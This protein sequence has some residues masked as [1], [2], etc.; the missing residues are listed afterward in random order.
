MAVAEIA[1]LN[2]ICPYYTMYPLTFPIAALARA[3]R[4]P[5]WV[6]DPFCGRGTTNYAAR[7]L[8]LPTIG[9]DSSPVAAA[10]AAAKMADTTEA[11]V[12]R[13]AREILDEGD[14]GDMPSGRF[15]E[16]AYH[17]QVL[18]DLCRL[19]TAL[20]RDCTSDARIVLRAIILG[21]LHGPTAKGAPFNFSNQAP[22]S[23]APKPNYAVK[24]WRERRLKPPKVDV[25]EVIRRRAE[26]YLAAV[27]PKVNGYIALGDSRRLEIPRGVHPRWVVTSPPYYGTRTYVPDQWLR[28]W[29]LGGPARVEYGQRPQDLSHLSSEVFASGLGAVWRRVAESAHKQATLII[30]FGAIGD[31]EVDPR[32]LL[33][34]SLSG[35]GWRLV[36]IRRAGDASDGKRQ[37]QQ[38]GRVTG[39]PRLEYD[40]YARLA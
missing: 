13:S 14:E 5:G 3:V 23:F 15:W 7:L 18:R 40:F 1:S 11:R 17:P 39:R 16:L 25:L 19:R 22:R 24:F 26:R 9:Q 33:R 32:A 4:E 31:R 10:I 34:A 37:A 2:G 12:V 20:L 35:S 21:A 29:F 38:F 6:L 27:P 36:T 30:R 28:G 8:G